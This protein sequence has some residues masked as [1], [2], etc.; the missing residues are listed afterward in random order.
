MES[1]TTTD[2]LNL[3]NYSI[4]IPYMNDAQLRNNPFQRYPCLCIDS[5]LNSNTIKN[6]ELNH[7]IN[8]SNSFYSA[9]VFIKPKLDSGAIPCHKEIEEIT[10]P[11]T[12]EPNSEEKSLNKEK[13]M[14]K[15]RLELNKEIEHN[16]NIMK[17]LRL[18]DRKSV[19]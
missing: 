18:P 10:E 14:K 9:K 7:D 15:F 13:S 11:E 1:T 6:T 5:H 4:V 3:P 8:Y 16:F 17:C 2:E 12:D 19:V